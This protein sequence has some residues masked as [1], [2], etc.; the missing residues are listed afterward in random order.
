MNKENLL[1][2]AE[3]K[4]ITGGD[5]PTVWVCNDVAYNC[6]T[7]YSECAFYCQNVYEGFCQEVYGYC[8]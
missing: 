5:P 1:S 2:K 8:S 3:M 4:K 6:H 7:T